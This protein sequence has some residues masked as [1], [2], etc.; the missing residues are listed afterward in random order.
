MQTGGPTVQL[1]GQNTAQLQFTTPEV[2]ED[3]LVSFSLVV[4]DP[5][6]AVSE[7]ITVSVK[8]LNVNK[9]PVAQARLVAGGTSG[10]TVTL[11]ALGSA[12]PDGEK[13]TYKWEQTD[14]PGV[15]LSSDTEPTVTF[16][17]PS[18]K[19][20]ITLGFKVTVTDSHGASAS[21]TVSVGVTA[22]KDQGGC[23]STGSSSGGAMLIAL[24]AGVAL[25]RRRITLR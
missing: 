10:E 8:V 24:L 11:D 12:D 7:P 16:T 9:A 21:E 1:T 6:G 23:A 18:T 2:S 19:T 20:N 22:P 14:G 5:D 15:S 13:L 17:A 25:S 4:T 3:M